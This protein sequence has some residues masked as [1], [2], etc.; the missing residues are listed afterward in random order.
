MLTRLETLVKNLLEKIVS[1]L[2]YSKECLLL[3][4]RVFYR[5]LEVL[6]RGNQLLV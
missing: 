1:L 5:L 2:D 4:V 3:H 6:V